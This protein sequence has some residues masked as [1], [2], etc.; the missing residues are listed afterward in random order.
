MAAPY[1]CLRGQLELVLAV[2]CGFAAILL[3]PAGAESGGLHLVAV[4]HRQ[5]DRAESHRFRLRCTGLFTTLARHHRWPRIAGT[6]RSDTLLV[7]DEL[8][9]VTQKRPEKSA[10]LLANGNGNPRQ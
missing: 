8:A 2:S 3:H 7:L 10:Y 4:Q 1:R 9:Q 6:L 5:N